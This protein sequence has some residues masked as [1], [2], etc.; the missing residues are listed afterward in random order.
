MITHP[1]KLLFPNDGITKGEVAAYYELVAPAMVP[2]IKARPVTMERFPSGIG[3][4]G[5]M[6]KN[7]AKGFPASLKRIE[8]PK[9][10]GTVKYPLVYTKEDLLWLAN[11]NTITVH[12]WPSRVPKLMFPDLVVFDL[13]PSIEDAD[14]LRVAALS[15]RD[16][17]EELG[18][19]SWVK[20]SGSKGYHIVV[21]LD[22]KTAF[23]EVGAF[24]I[25]AARVLVER[26]PERFTLEFMKADRGDRIYADVGRNGPGATYAAPYTVR[27]KPG[28]PVSAPCTWDEIESGTVHPQSFNVRNMPR[29]LEDVDDLW[30]GIHTKGRS[31]RRP[32]QKLRHLLPEP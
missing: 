12:V 15:V 21:P 28:A 27:P 17:L 9:K 13:D 11:Q 32:M 19:D 6:Q 26:Y 1:E 5:F 10:G 24:A 22:G 4:T 30:A 14:G 7:V 16:L 23:D 29:R 31:L 20:T 2:L 25:Q 18:L 3:H 8:V